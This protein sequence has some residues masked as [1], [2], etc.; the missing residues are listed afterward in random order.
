MPTRPVAPG[1]MPTILPPPARGRETQDAGAGRV[2]DRG[3]SAGY[4][5]PTSALIVEIDEL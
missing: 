5:Q 3:R 1:V 4:E 2:R